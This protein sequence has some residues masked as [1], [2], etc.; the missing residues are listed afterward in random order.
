[1]LLYR[2]YH[3]CGAETAMS[4]L[5]AGLL[6]VPTGSAEVLPHVDIVATTARDFR[7]GEVPTFPLSDGGPV[8]FFMLEGNQ[9]TQDIPA[10][11]TITLDMIEKPADS[12][13]WTLRQQ[14]D[15]HFLNLKKMH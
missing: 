12:A 14:Q 8:P 1:M 2:P 13:L 3:L 10:G 7:A 5:C 15:A 11:M 4:I 6:C 9:L